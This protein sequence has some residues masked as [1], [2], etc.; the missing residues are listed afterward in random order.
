MG[1]YTGGKPSPSPEYKQEPED[2]GK[3]GSIEVK[4]G[5]RNLFDGKFESG[6][7]RQDNGEN[8]DY[9]DRIRTAGFIQINQ[10]QC[11]Q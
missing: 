5:G 4:V 7:I 2:A 11:T 3:D 10:V 8:Q 1:A 9:A 6:S